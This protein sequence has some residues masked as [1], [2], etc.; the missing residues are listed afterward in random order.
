MHFIF[1]IDSKWRYWCSCLIY[2][3]CDMKDYINGLLLEITDRWEVFLSF[4]SQE[5]R[6]SLPVGTTVVCFLYPFENEVDAH[7]GFWSIISNLLW[8]IERKVLGVEAQRTRTG[9]R[10][11]ERFRGLKINSQ[12]DTDNVKKSL[13]ERERERERVRERESKEKITAKIGVKIESNDFQNSGPL[14]RDKR[15]TAQI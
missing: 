3:L 10:F 14:G 4:Y 6:F 9:A 2:L 11:Y 12:G 13:I 15:K 7:N 8:L 1:A 5:K